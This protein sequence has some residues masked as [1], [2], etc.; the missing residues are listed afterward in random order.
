VYICTDIFLTKWERNIHNNYCPHFCT[1]HLIVAGIYNYLF[2]ILILIPSALSKYL[3]DSCYLPKG[4][5]HTLIPK[6]SGPF[7]LELLCF[8]LALI[9]GHGNIKRHP[10][11]GIS[12][13]LGMLFFYLHCGGS[14]PISPWLFGSITPANTIISI[15]AC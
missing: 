9:K 3:S 8:S 1:G 2:V 10:S 5:T 11:A 15:L 12:C 6:G 7:V 13:T 14:S 4:V